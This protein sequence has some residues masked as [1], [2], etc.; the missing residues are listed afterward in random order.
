MFGGE[1]FR[2]HGR[3][4]SRQTGVS[5]R[6]IDKSH[7]RIAENKARTVVVQVARECEA[8]FLQFEECR[9]CAELAEREHRGHI[10][11]TAERLAKTDGSEIPMVVI[12]RIV[13]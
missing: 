11:R 2:A 12:L 5:A 13:I 8:P 10:Q 6:K 3:S 4:I 9:A 7:F 1:E